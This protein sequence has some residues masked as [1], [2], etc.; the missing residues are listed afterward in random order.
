MTSVP[1]SFLRVGEAPLVIG[2]VVFIKFDGTP[3]CYQR[4]VTGTIDDELFTAAGPSDH[5]VHIVGEI[6]SINPAG[7]RRGAPA[8]LARLG[9]LVE[10]FDRSE[11]SDPAFIDSQLDN[12][13]DVANSE[14]YEL[15]DFTAYGIAVGAPVASSRPGGI[16]PST[17]VA[18][19]HPSAVRTAAGDTVG[20]LPGGGLA[21]PRF[22]GLATATAKASPSALVWVVTDLASVNFGTV[23]EGSSV[24][25]RS[26]MDSGHPV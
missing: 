21:L 22:Q 26:V 2:Q 24:I 11:I 14:G 20:A 25:A 3:G 18:G 1:Q 19:I 10:R 16:G 8:G 9:G 23:V 12:A 13:E 5:Y 6:E 4:I 17:D 7:V 15:V